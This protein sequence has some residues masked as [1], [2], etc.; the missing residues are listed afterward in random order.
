VLLTSGGPKLLDAEIAH[1]GD[2]AFDVGQLVAHLLL[3]SI[4]RGETEPGRA[5]AGAAWN[6]YAAAFGSTSHPVF[7]DTALYAG[8][9]MLRRTLGAARAAAVEVEDAALEVVAA[10][11]RLVKNPPASPEEL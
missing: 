3:P 4:A 1:V 2:P 11:I 8:I 9:E 10:E 6:A 5:A 7:S